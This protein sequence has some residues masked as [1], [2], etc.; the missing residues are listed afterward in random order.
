[1]FGGIKKEVRVGYTCP[2]EGIE[3]YS[4]GMEELSYDV[5]LWIRNRVMECE[6]KN[7][8]CPGNCTMKQQLII[9]EAKYNSK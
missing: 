9:E 5:L 6:V 3:R 8:P 2:I 4:N 7:G 1:M